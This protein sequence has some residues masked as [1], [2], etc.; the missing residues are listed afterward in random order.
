MKGARGI[1][2]L[3]CLLLTAPAV[4]GTVYRCDSADGGRSY[5]SKRVPGAKCTAVSS[6]TTKAYK[7]PAAPVAAGSATLDSTAEGSPVSASL[8]APAS[9]AS[10]VAPAA[11]KPWQAPRLVQGQVYS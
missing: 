10:P 5:S 4:A 6:Y 1:L 9:P 8:P 11:Q 7:S 3:T 2:A